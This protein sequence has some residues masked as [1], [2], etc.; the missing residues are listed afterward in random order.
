MQLWLDRTGGEFI[1]QGPLNFEIKVIQ[2]RRVDSVLSPHIIT[3]QGAVLSLDDAE[4]LRR[5]VSWYKV[6][7]TSR[8]SLA[9]LTIYRGDAVFQC[10][11]V[12]HPDARPVF[13]KIL[14]IVALDCLVDLLGNVIARTGLGCE[15][16]AE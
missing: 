15:L 16:F 13:L 11:L 2:K 1:Q 6:A 10:C 12:A 4:A 14:A 5:W 3:D 7:N 8:F 9:G